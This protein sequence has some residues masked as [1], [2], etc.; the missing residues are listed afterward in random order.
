MSSAI[1]LHR[2]DGL[3]GMLARA[4]LARSIRRAQLAFLPQLTHSSR[5][6]VVGGG[7]GPFL[8]D[9]L[10]QTSVDYVLYVE[11]SP[12]TLSLARTRLIRQMPWALRRVEFRLGSL[13]IGASDGHFDLVV[14]HFLFEASSAS[15]AN[16]LGDRLVER[17]AGWS[18]WLLIDLNPPRR[19]AVKFYARRVFDLRLQ[20]LRNLLQLGEAAHVESAPI[21]E[22]LGVHT[23][24]ARCSQLSLVRARLLSMLPRATLFPEAHAGA[25][26]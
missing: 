8:T 9:L 2:P 3:V 15:E 16:L 14:T 19:G 26:P 6:L 25:L 13:P 18:T 20:M 10:Q 24:E 4:L 5:A 23:R 1:D 7:F 11:T 17:M 12:R 22:R 21:F